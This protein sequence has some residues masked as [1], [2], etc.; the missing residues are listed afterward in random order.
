MPFGVGFGPGCLEQ[1]PVMQRIGIVT[2]PGF[3]I[4]NVAA[5]SV[6]EV[7]NSC[8]EERRYKVCFISERG[9]LVAAPNGICVETE[10]FDELTILDL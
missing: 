9:G 4:M 3:H 2:S 5:A 1:E 6:F 7:A 10:A 8:L